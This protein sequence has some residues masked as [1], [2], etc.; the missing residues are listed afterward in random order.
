MCVLYAKLLAYNSLYLFH[1]NVSGQNQ[2][3][4]SPSTSSCWLTMIPPFRTLLR[5]ATFFNPQNNPTRNVVLIKERSQ[6]EDFFSKHQPGIRFSVACDLDWR[7][8]IPKQT[9][10][11]GS[12]NVS[13]NETKTSSTFISNTKEIKLLSTK[14]EHVHNSNLHWQ[15]SRVYFEYT[16]FLFR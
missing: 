14:V 3:T 12:F 11:S 5:L 9:N 4:P 13:V 16:S 1:S 7:V 6:S 15:L 8:S 10:E 2:S